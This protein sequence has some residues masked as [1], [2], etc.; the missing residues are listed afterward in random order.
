MHGAHALTVATCL[1][2]QDRRRFVAAHAVA[3]GVLRASLRCAGAD[4]P[5]HAVKVGMLPDAATAE[6]VA[7]E[8]AKFA[9]PTVVDPVLSATAGG[10]EVGPDLVAAFRHF[11]RAD[12]VLTP[13]RPELA[14]LAEDADALLRQ[15]FGAVLVKGGHDDGDEVVD[16]LWTA[17]GAVRELR[18]PRR[19]CGA[20]H[21]TGC[22]LAAALAARLAHGDDIAAAAA[23]AVAWVDA[24]LAGLAPA[25]GDLPRPFPVRESALPA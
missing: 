8:V 16:R 14:L 17:T 1:T 23:A 4:G 19:P 7:E 15:G 18:H 25:A 12:V 11:A 24:C 13:N 10:L 2:V 20:V 5:V 9:A 3:E 22:A 6:L 21:G